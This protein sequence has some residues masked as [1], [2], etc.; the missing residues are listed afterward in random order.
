MRC[1]RCADEPLF[2]PVRRWC[3]ILRIG[4][5]T[6]MLAALDLTFWRSMLFILGVVMA[7]GLSVGEHEVLYHDGPTDRRPAH[8]C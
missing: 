5:G 8:D 7:V 3:T 2:G 1:E 6:G 4:A